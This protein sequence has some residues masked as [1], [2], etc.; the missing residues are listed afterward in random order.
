MTHAAASQLQSGYYTRLY[1]IIIIR[2]II[3]NQLFCYTNYILHENHRVIDNGFRA[4]MNLLCHFGI[5]EVELRRE[6]EDLRP[7][8]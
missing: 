2:K 4:N 8:L 7:T 6:R 5:G 1:E 3:R